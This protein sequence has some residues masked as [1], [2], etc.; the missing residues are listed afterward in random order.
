ML[1]EEVEAG[2]K[3]VRTDTVQMTIGE[4]ASMYE[5]GELNIHP[6]F[7][8]LFRWTLQKKSDFVESILVGIPVP[9][10]FA[11]EGGDG[12]WELVDGLQRI[13]TL[14]EFMG[15]LRS[16]D[17]ENLRLRSILAK[18]SYLPGLEG[19]AWDVRQDDPQGTTAL[20]KSLQLMF[21]RSRVDFQVLKSP[22]DEDTK[23]ELFQRLNRGGEYANEQ[24]VR[25]CVMVMKNAAYTKSLREIA[26]R[27]QFKAV[28]RVSEDQERRQIDV[29]MVVRCAVHT[30]VDYDDK[31]D[32]QDFLD[33]SIIKIMSSVPV[34]S[35]T[36]TLNRTID[37]LFKNL[38][39]QALLPKEGAPK[40]IAN[41]F[42]LRALEAIF[43]GAARNLEKIAALASPDEYVLNQVKTFWAQEEV[44][45]MSSPGLTGTQRLKRTIPFGAKWFD[46]DGHN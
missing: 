15:V 43:V 44:K 18:T 23:F 6:A 41:R 16:P 46:P 36:N 39:D 10:V 8:R 38:G 12:L 5:A 31:S 32:V 37:V 9:P 33:K 40:D 4:I 24:E 21:R 27:P 17:D 28:F 7:Q 35:V 22:S 2:K 26:D 3:L 14:L 13:S 29:E 20:E 30:F 19:T 42:S 34:E 11:Y 45:S 25:T 1:K